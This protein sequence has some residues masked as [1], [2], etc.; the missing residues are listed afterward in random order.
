LINHFDE[1]EVQEWPRD[2]K[3]DEA[4]EALMVELFEQRHEV[5][6]GRQIAVFFERRFYHWI[7]TKALNELA[8]E[9][10]IRS[11]TEGLIGSAEGEMIRFYWSK[12]TRYFRR[13]MQEIQ[14]LVHEFSTPDMMR[15]LGLHGEAMFD[16]G[17]A[18]FGWSEKARHARAF[19][20]KE[21]TQTGHNLDRISERDGVLYG[22][23]VKNALSYVDRIELITK[24]EMCKFL[25]LRPLFI[26]RMAPKNYIELVRAAGGFTLVFEWQLYPYGQEQLAHRVRE[27]LGLKVD[28][29]QGITDGTMQ[30]L[31]NWHLKH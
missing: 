5:F 27:R 20:G 31:L 4:K 17:L 16:V 26:M 2:A 13:Q 10:R 30:R 22:V 25:D 12:R 14:K 21:W 18:R 9:G 3:V 24:I 23:E 28:C 7:T 6:Y 1:P 11:V 15:A 29:P 19:R 8:D